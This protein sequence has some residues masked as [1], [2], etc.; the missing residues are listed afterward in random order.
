MMPTCDA[1][2]AAG[3]EISLLR[4]R[5]VLGSRPTS[6]TGGTNH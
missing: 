5:H 6:D 4:E 1:E 2:R 3:E